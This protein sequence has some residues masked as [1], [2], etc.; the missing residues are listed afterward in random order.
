LSG[1]RHYLNAGQDGLD[2]D[3]AFHYS[4]RGK[5]WRP[6]ASASYRVMG[7]LPSNRQTGKALTENTAAES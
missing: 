1:D 4:I 5:T 2:N 7:H 3:E 6:A